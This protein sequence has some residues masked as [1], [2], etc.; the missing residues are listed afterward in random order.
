MMGG[1]M[2]RPVRAV[3]VGGSF[4]VHGGM[5]EAVLWVS[6]LDGTMGV[7]RAAGSSYQL[8]GRSI[9]GDGQMERGSRLTRPRVR[10]V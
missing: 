4:L 9:D 6:I 2:P 1:P 7:K 10:F 5:H 3:S 8:G